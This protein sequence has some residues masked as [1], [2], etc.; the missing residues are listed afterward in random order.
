MRVPYFLQ[1][2]RKACSLVCISWSSV[3]RGNAQD[4]K[5]VQ[6]QADLAIH[7]AMEY[8]KASSCVRMKRAVQRATRLSGNFMLFV[9][10]QLGGG[11]L[12]CRS[13]TLSDCSPVIYSEAQKT[14]SWRGRGLC[15]QIVETI[16]IPGT[17]SFLTPFYIS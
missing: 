10:L 9:L 16:P 13:R 3:Q 4:L 1:R 2:R 11:S 14:V 15:E 17:E 6:K 5:V 7:P 8:R 12:T